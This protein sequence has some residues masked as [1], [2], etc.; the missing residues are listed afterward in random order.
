MTPPTEH[1]LTFLP[2]DDDDLILEDWMELEEEETELDILELD[3]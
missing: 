3:D 1:Q 2:Q